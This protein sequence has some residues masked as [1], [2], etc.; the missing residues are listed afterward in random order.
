MLVERSTVDGF[1]FVSCF[2][3]GLIVTSFLATSLLL[4]VIFA[5]TVTSLETAVNTLPSL[6]DL[7][8]TYLFL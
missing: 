8:I 5:G 7:K 2:G 1:A 4:T 6:E 3:L